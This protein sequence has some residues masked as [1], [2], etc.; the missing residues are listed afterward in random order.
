MWSKLR[1]QYYALICA[2]VE[3]LCICMLLCF[4][5]DHYQLTAAATLKLG[6]FHH[7]FLNVFA[8]VVDSYLDEL[9]VTLVQDLNRSFA[10]EMW[11]PVRYDVIMMS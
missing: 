6:E 3:P 2:L 9:E 5:H 1:P 10:V 11:M 8:P 7:N 4:A